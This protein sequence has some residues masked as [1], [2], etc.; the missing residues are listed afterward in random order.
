MK[1]LTNEE[2]EKLDKLNDIFLYM[3]GYEH[4]N[5]ICEETD[6]LL[7]EYSDIEI[8]ESL[9]QRF[10][11]FQKDLNRKK[12]LKNI[13]EK[14]IKI[15]KKIAAILIVII[16]ISTLVT[17]SV[18]ANRIKFFNMIIETTKRFSEVKFKETDDLEYIKDLP[19]DWDDFYY[20]TILPDGYKLINSISANEIRYLI[21]A[22]QDNNELRFL[23]G[24]ITSAFQLDT[25]DANVFKVDINGMEGIIIEKDGVTIISWHD[26]NRSFYLQG[27]IEKSILL[28]IGKSIEKNK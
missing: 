11:D 1:K 7:E 22:D 2:Q 6:Q 17:M 26:N 14:I 25:E 16:F 20:P 24:S 13:R 10:I 19:Q 9:D 28:E 3:I 4:I 8:P 18:E 23:Q 27:K 12:K 21:F 15:S 5:N